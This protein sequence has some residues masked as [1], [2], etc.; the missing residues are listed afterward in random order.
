M[1]VIVFQEKEEEEVNDEGIT[2][3][4]GKRSREK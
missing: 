1:L 2:V 4:E 3:N